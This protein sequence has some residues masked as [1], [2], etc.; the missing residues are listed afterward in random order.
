ME[1]LLYLARLTVTCLL[2]IGLMISPSGRVGQT[3]DQTELQHEVV[4]TLKLIQV[5]VL[6]ESGRPVTDLTMDDFVVFDNGRRQ[7]IT[8]F[9]KHLLPDK[10]RG[11]ETLD[12]TRP[13]DA[14]AVPPQLSRKF[15]FLFDLD[16]ISLEGFNRAKEAALY[17]LDSQVR[18]G[19]QVGLLTYSVLRGMTLYAYLSSDFPEVREKLEAFREN[20]GR[21]GGGASLWGMRAEALGEF[22]AQ[23]G[24][25][26]TGLTRGVYGESARQRNPEADWHEKKNLEFVQQMEEVAKSLRTIPGYK[27][28]IL[29]SNGFPRSLYEGDTFFQRNYEKMAQEFATANSPVHTINT[30]GG[31]QYS[32]S[33]GSR[34]D[35]SLKNLSQFSG[36]RHFQNV[37][38]HE[39]IS[40]ELQAMTGNYY[41][42]GY[43]AGEV[44]DGKYHN[45]K[46]DVKRP[47]C[48]VLAQSGYFNP[49]PF[50]KF[51]DF[52]KQL[53][54]YDLA[55]NDMPQLQRN[56]P[57]IPLS[58]LPYA[59]QDDNLVL[60]AGIDAP[61][62]EEILGERAELIT[63]IY[64]SSFQIHLSTQVELNKGTFQADHVYHY[65]LESL[66]PGSYVCRVV[67]R[68]LE[69]GKGAVGRAETT[70]SEPM[71]AGIKLFPPLLFKP[72]GTAVFHRA[73]HGGDKQDQRSLNDLYPFLGEET[74]PLFDALPRERIPLMAVLRIKVK[75]IAEPDTALNMILI[76]DSGRKTA[77]PFEVIDVKA[78]GE[79]D[80]LLLE[81]RLP[82]ISPGIFTLEITAHDHASGSEASVTRR[83]IF[84]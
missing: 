69:T 64:D 16:R 79:Y 59:E 12:E 35:S 25:A 47:G 34:G 13:E 58:A 53:H 81:M 56:T 45:L 18:P 80:S 37:R 82:R 38:E 43:Y 72:G 31:R 27:N 77:V 46:V 74:T 60:L 4:V 65:S 57:S 39:S 67:I 2:G 29:F 42:L 15:F 24:Y 36:G 1:N 44:A 73:V 50:T 17:F 32:R 41:V 23:T 5:Y 68:N 78:D 71:E 51:T 30:E 10:I 61:A 3:P 54:L 9:E 7:D 75:G 21:P 63:M 8:E 14:R 48:R 22:Q 11:E 40:E 19:D 33:P 66:P 84:R 76:D 62:L 83:I 28:V 70:I 55:M 52:E 49:K 26:L 20:L 6:D